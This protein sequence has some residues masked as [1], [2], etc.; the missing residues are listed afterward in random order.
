MDW[1]SQGDSAAAQLART[2]RQPGQPQSRWIRFGAYAAFGMANGS[3][4]DMQ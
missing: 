3:S 4:Q 1:E 2:R